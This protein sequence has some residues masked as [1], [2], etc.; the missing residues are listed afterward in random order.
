MKLFTNYIS[1]SKHSFKVRVFLV[2]TFLHLGF[3]ILF[4]GITAFAPDEANYIRVFNN[5]YRSDFSIDGYLGWHEGSINGLRLIY[6]PG[7]ILA[8]IGF[9][10][11]YAVRILSVFYSMLSLYLLLKLAPEYKIL[12]LPI[13]FWLVSAFL[14]PSIFLWTSIGLRESFIFFSLVAIFYLLSNPKKLCFRKQFVLLAAAS[15]FLLISKIY[16]FVLLLMCFVTSTLFLF[17]LRK[18]IQFSSLKLLSAFLVPLLIFP[19]IA[20]NIAAEAERTLEYKLL[21]PTPPPTPTPTPTPP[22]TPPPTGAIPARGQMVHD[23]YQEF[24]KNPFLSRLLTLT[25]IEGILQKKVE[26]SYLQADSVELSNNMAQLQRKPA[27][28]RKPLSLLVGA[29][30]FLFVPTPFIDNGSFFLNAQSYESFIWYFFYLIFLI[31]LIGLIRGRYAL[32]QVTLSSSLFSL[33][34]IA[35]STFIEVNDGTSV[36]HRAVLLVGI[37]VMLANFLP[38]AEEDFIK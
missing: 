27:S 26:S 5:L 34:F 12:K 18:K 3:I 6:L 35:L 7:K 31:L 13:R 11:F 22:P 28:L 32:N 1:R 17:L 4:D 20:T 19:A 30:N 9:S 23:L 24:E 8:I 14:I 33:G 2:I 15:T 29:Y 16:L 25:G 38:K 37:L 21:A 10:D 36:R